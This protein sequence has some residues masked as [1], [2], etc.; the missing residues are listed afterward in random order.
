MQ[1]GAAVSTW[2]EVGLAAVDGLE[3]GLAVADCRQQ[4]NR[5]RLQSAWQHQLQV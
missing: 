3:V 5:F 2:E 1:P 4:D